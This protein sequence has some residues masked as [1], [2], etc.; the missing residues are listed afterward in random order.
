M[1]KLQNSGRGT[2]K[3]IPT[4]ILA[5]ATID[6]LYCVTGFSMASSIVFTEIG[7]RGVDFLDEDLNYKF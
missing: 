3:G 6:N 1:I 7:G 4:M 5:S 2:E